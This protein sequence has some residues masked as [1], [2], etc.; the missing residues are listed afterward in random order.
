MG[1]V[2]RLIGLSSVISD[3]CLL[4]QVKSWVVRGVCN[5]SALWVIVGLLTKHFIVLTALWVKE[6][7]N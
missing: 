7:R 6:M 5:H 1:E 2:E 4:F 3:Y